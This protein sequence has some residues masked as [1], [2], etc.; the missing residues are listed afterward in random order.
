MGRM[1][2]VL[3]VAGSF[4]GGRCSIEGVRHHASEVQAEKEVQF[5]RWVALRVD[6]HRERGLGLQRAP[7]SLYPSSPGEVLSVALP[8]WRKMVASS[9]RCASADAEKLFSPDRQARVLDVTVGTDHV[10]P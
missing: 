1:G 8:A 10:P 4:S 7:H 5:L 6:G 3:L 9:S 2:D